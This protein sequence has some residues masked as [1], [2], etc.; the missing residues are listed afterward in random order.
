V[1]SKLKPL[2]DSFNDSDYEA[3]EENDASFSEGEDKKKAATKSTKSSSSSS[4]HSKTGRKR[5]NASNK[6]RS[7]F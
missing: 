1:L 4:Q 6:S 7:G 3:S 2:R 5:S